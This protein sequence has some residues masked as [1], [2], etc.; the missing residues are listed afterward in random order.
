[1]SADAERE[2]LGVLAL[3]TW[4]RDEEPSA[5]RE[6]G[7]W[8]GQMSE[9][10]ALE[11]LDRSRIIHVADRESDS[12]EVLVGLQQKG[13]R[14]VLRSSKE[15][16]LEASV[17]GAPKLHDALETT[18]VIVEREVALT[19]R[20]ASGR[21]KT[22][23]KTNPPRNARMAQL[24][25]GARPLSF[26]RPRG[27]ELPDSCAVN[28][29]RVW[30]PSPPPGEPAVEWVLFTSEPIESAEQLETIVDHY[31]ARWRIEAY[32]KALKTGCAFERR[33]L[34][35]DEA[36][37]V[38]LAVFVPLAWRMLIL[39]DSAQ[40]APDAPASTVWAEDE[41]IVLRECTNTTELKPQA[42][43]GA[44]RHRWPRGTSQEK[45][46]ARLA[47]HCTRPGDSSRARPGFPNR[48]EVKTTM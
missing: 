12:Y 7:R 39:R 27:K 29:V 25:L 15:R 36:L 41:I 4:I 10:S 48:R 9:V 34:E 3:Y 8:L 47:H 45:W 42:K 23:N 6:R 33:Q 18:R 21:S 22:A 44:T 37:C 46:R 5:N 1:L 38:A 26:L 16:C 43:T 24:A 19:A 35:S 14:Y 32:F 28:V 13:L 17:D 20:S 30:E 2:A 40:R 31:R 11:G